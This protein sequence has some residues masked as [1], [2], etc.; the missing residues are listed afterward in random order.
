[1]DPKQVTFKTNG[2]DDDDD[3]SNDNG[4]LVQADSA[5]Q[6]EKPRIKENDTLLNDTLLKLTKNTT[7]Q[8]LF[9]KFKLH[10]VYL[11]ISTPERHGSTGKNNNQQHKKNDNKR[12]KNLPESLWNLKETVKQRRAPA[13]STDCPDFI[14]EPWIVI[15][16]FVIGFIILVWGLWLAV[17]FV[18]TDPQDVVTRQSLLSS[19][20]YQMYVNTAILMILGML[21]PWRMKTQ[22]NLY[23]IAFIAL[24][25]QYILYFVYFSRFKEPSI[26]LVEF[27]QLKTKVSQLENHLSELAERNSMPTPVSHENFGFADPLEVF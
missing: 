10:S 22:V 25:T 11:T 23:A 27:N 7:N 21:V 12:S 13:T 20:N 19:V 16:V 2:N 4:R 15:S 18:R 14:G 1:M 3:V 9:E 26:S 6:D 8:K 5:K 24:W 17:S